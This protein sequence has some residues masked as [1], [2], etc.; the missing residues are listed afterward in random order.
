MNRSH[1]TISHFFSP[2]LLHCYSLHRHP[3][4]SL[5]IATCTYHAALERTKLIALTMRSDFS[6]PSA[7]RLYHRGP[8]VN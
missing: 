4:L 6:I 7:V 8:P 2:R 3:V 1:L 5:K